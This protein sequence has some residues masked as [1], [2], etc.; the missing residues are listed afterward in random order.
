MENAPPLVSSYQRGHGESDDLDAAVI[1]TLG[2]KVVVIT[3]VSP[4]HGARTVPTTQ[5]LVIGHTICESVCMSVCMC[6]CVCQRACVS[7]YLGMLRK[8]RH[9]SFNS[10]TL[11]VRSVPSHCGGRGGEGRGG[12]VD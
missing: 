9:C 1:V 10:W 11:D 7:I 5:T 4:G 12:E 3:G 6:V 2:F 8:T